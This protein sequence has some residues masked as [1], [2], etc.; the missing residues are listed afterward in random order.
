MDAI[1][2]LKVIGDKGIDIT[3]NICDGYIIGES[4]A[5]RSST[6]IFTNL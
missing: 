6:L 5:N 4:G 1:K 3:Y 2:D